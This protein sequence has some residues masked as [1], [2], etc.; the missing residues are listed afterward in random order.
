MAIRRRVGRRGALRFELGGNPG[1][2]RNHDRQLPVGKVP[3]MSVVINNSAI[4]PTREGGIWTEESQAQ[5]LSRVCKLGREFLEDLSA[6]WPE[7]FDRLVF[8]RDSREQD[9][10]TAVYDE[11]IRGF[12]FLLDEGLIVVW[13]PFDQAEH[14]DWGTG[15][16]EPEI[17]RDAIQHIGECLNRR[18]E[19]QSGTSTPEGGAP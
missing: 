9:P 1:E 19:P 11:P 14:A 15:S 18:L 5:A 8:L 3:Y 16:T 12:G 10:V 7:V 17:C 2:L 6:A 4:D 13:S